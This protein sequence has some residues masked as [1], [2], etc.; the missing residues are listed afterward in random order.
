MYEENSRLEDEKRT[1]SIDKDVHGQIYRTCPKLDRLVLEAIYI[2]L[3]I[4][5][6]YTFIPLEYWTR[7]KL[8]YSVNSSSIRD[9]CM[10]HK[11][12]LNSQ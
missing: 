12:S 7:D 10:D 2:S 1:T 6:G 4:A 5:L 3:D 11:H 8:H 9:V